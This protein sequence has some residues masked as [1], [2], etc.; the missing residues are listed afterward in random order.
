VQKTVLTLTA[1]H[2]LLLLHC[3]WYTQLCTTCRSMAPSRLGCLKHTMLTMQLNADDDLQQLLPAGPLTLMWAAAK[4]VKLHLV[5]HCAWLCLSAQP[6][7]K[8]CAPCICHICGITQ[9]YY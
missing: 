1:C 5:S 8:F 9:V 6:A 7:S 4:A 3:P 2:S